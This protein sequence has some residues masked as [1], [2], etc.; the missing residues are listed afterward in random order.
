[1]LLRRCTVGAI[2]VP[3]AVPANTLEPGVNS[4]VGLTSTS[5]FAAPCT[6]SHWSSGSKTSGAG[7][8]SSTRP[9]EAVGQSHENVPIRERRPLKL[10][11]SSGVTA[12]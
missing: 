8:R 3:F 1:V 12:Q 11:W 5:Y 4:L 2:E 7:S 10:P 6:V 9:V